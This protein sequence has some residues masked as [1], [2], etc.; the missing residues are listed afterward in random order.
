MT[1]K[2]NIGRSI[3]LITEE[4][5]RGMSGVP[6]RTVT[7][8]CAKLKEAFVF[9]HY[10]AGGAGFGNRQTRM[11]MRHSGYE[12]EKGW[13]ARAS[14]HDETLLKHSAGNGDCSTGR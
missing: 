4:F 5:I 13:N 3:N 10:C 12:G 14:T 8:K 7:K 1:R 11:R 6:I 9:S 2:K